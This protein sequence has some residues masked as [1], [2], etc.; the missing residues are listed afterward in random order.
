MLREPWNRIGRLL[1]NEYTDTATLNQRPIFASD[2][3]HNVQH[4]HIA[5]IDGA[6]YWFQRGLLLA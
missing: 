3:A 6:L 4:R 2:L 5:Q 1:T